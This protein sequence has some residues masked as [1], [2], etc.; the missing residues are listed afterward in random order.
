MRPSDPTKV[1]A[2]FKWRSE[3]NDSDPE[4]VREL[5][6]RTGVFSSIENGWA[7][8]LV[9]E[10]LKRGTA[11]GYHFIFADRAEFLMG[12]TCFG[13]IEGTENRFD[14][15]WIATHPVA[16]GQGL[17]RQ[18]LER[19]V[20]AARAMGASHMFI[21]TSTREDYA[22]ARALY[23]GCGFIQMGDLVDFYR[24]GDGK[25]IFGRKL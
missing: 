11:S 23:R 10:R 14:L 22:P 13:P 8:E 19:S 5:V 1:T 17:G 25:A 15:Y 18:L 9:E 12:Y 20:T 21:D 3:P 2:P 16:Q 7:G 4:R 6:T 24:D